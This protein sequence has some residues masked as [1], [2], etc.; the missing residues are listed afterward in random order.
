MSRY[1]LNRYG[2]A[3]NIGQFEVKALIL[4]HTNVIEA[5]LVCQAMPDVKR[6]FKL[7][8]IDSYNKRIC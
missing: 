2:K 5:G 7:H 6:W 4:F 3:Q 1:L 8:S